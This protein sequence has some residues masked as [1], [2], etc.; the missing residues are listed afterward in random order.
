MNVGPRKPLRNFFPLRFSPPVEI[1]PPERLAMIEAAAYLR[2][3]RR[4]FAPGHHV[5]DWVEAERE[6]DAR[7]ARGRKLVGA[8]T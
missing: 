5:E 1:S 3:E 2:A 7:I 8:E 4:R 6:I